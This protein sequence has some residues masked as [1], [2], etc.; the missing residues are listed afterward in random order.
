[1]SV[2]TGGYGGQKI[3]EGVRVKTN[4]PVMPFFEIAMTGTIEPFAEIRPDHIRLSGKAGEPLVLEVEI[5]PR[6]DHPF[7]IVRLEAQNGTFIK[8]ELEAQCAQNGGHC[9]LRVENTRKEPG[10]YVDRILV[11]T[12]SPLRPTIPILVSGEIL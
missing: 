10:R 6:S 8:Y 1:M 11:H 4:D 9:L 5:V 7:N 2:D 12:D 3:R